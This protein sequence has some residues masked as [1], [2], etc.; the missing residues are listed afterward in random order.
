MIGHFRTC[1]HQPKMGL[2]RGLE[3]LFY[4]FIVEWSKH[5]R[6]WCVKKIYIFNL[7]SNIRWVV[8]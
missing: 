8:L 3:N 1:H 5:L 2:R 4:G 6:N 7:D